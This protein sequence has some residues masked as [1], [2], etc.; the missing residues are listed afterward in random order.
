[1][2]DVY[3]SEVNPANGRYVCTPEHPMPEGATGRWE[4]TNVSET[5]SSSDYT[6]SYKCDDCGLEWREEL[7]E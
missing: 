1:M 7:P 2:T 3:L 6:A 4:H 5:D